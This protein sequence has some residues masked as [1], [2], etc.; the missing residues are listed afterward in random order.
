M[1]EYVKIYNINFSNFIS[2]SAND[3]HNF[4][5]DLSDSGTVLI[6]RENVPVTIPDEIPQIKN[7]QPSENSLTGT[8][9]S[10]EDHPRLYSVLNSF[11]NL[12]IITM[13]AK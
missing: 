7:N 5:K 11:Q 10:T 2:Q 12:M 6:T 1:N 13:L 3:V 4:V 9:Y 8:L